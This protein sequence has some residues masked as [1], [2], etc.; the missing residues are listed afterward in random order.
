VREALVVVV[1]EEQQDE[2]VAMVEVVVEEELHKITTLKKD[3]GI[4][5]ICGN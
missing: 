3:I 1:L 4:T 5:E 2:A